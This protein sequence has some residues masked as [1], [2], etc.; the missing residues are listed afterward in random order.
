MRERRRG[1]ER[2]KAKARTTDIPSTKKKNLGNDR[3]KLAVARS[4]TRLRLKGRGVSTSKRDKTSDE[5]PA[6]SLSASPARNQHSQCQFSPGPCGATYLLQRDAGKL[7]LDTPRV[8]RHVLLDRS[9]QRRL[10]HAQAG[11]R[12]EGLELADDFARWRRR[13]R[14]SRTSGNRGVDEGRGRGGGAGVGGGVA[15]LEVLLGET[16]SDHLCTSETVVSAGVGTA[17]QL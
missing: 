10:S 11:R 13:G 1:E 2:N 5:G 8:V 9:S 6:H 15:R 14:D 3:I 17:G 4:S 12:R 7:Q 16:R